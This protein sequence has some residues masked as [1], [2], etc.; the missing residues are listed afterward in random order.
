MSIIKIIIITT[1][2]LCIIS[3]KRNEVFSAKDSLL[4]IYADTTFFKEEFIPEKFMGIYG[5]WELVKI[6]GGPDG[7]GTKKNFDF[8]EV[9]RIGIYGYIKEGQLSEYG[10]FELDSA[11]QNDFE[12]QYPNHTDFQNG[13]LAIKMM[14]IEQKQRT[15]PPDEM[16]FSLTDSTMI[17]TPYP[18]GVAFNYHYRK[19]IS[20][21][22][23]AK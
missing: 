18:F 11:S 19:L 4:D 14:P 22:N 2:I 5:K 13:F 9:K 1:G 7:R 15:S 20:D 10:K 8:L 6:S 12:N 23:N 21:K 16:F 17:L 3:C